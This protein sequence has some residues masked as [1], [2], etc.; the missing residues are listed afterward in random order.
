MFPWKLR[1]STPSQRILLFL[2]LFPVAYVLLQ[3]IP[4]QELAAAALANENAPTV[5][6]VIASLQKDDIAWTSKLRI[7]NL[8]VIRYVSDAPNA[9]FRPPV[10]KKGREAT[11]FHTYFYDFYDFLPDIS[12]LI[13]AHEDPWH[14]EGVLQQSML[15]TLSHLDLEHVQKRQYANLR[16]SWKDACPDW[17]NTTKTPE[18][19]YKQEEPF[20]HQAFQSNFGP[21]DIPEILAGPCC[22]QFAV[23]RAAVRRNPRSQY[24]RNLDWLVSTDWSDYIA[25]RTWEHMFPWL[26]T[27]RPT[28]CPIEWKTYCQMYHVCFEHPEAASRYNA[29]WQEKLDLRED[30]EFW[31]ELPNPQRG[32]KARKRMDEID[33]ILQVQIEEAI[34]R[35]R[36]PKNRVA[37]DVFTP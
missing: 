19:S 20:M 2:L 36:N 8:K 4:Q 21:V 26:F 31:R 10:P 17:I 12:I 24:K 15:F 33:R 3:L 23:T 11:I 29:L 7:P 34:E 18:E 16:V 25:G 27:G 30:I 35:G 32:V 5:N 13:H 37:G 14:I 28:D 22:S 6:L 9:E 1:L